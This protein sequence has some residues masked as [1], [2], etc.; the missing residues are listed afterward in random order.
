M[1]VEG[2]M[3]RKMTIFCERN[4]ESETKGCQVR[5]GATIICKFRFT[6]SMLYPDAI[7]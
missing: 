5:V 3:L 1:R 6:L 4:M 7:S 2:Y